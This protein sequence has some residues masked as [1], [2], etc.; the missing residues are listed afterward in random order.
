MLLAHEYDWIYQR[1]FNC[2]GA[3]HPFDVYIDIDLYVRYGT[4]AVVLWCIFR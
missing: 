3:K 1:D 2:E 4:D